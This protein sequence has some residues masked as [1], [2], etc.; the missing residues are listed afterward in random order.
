MLSAP[1]GIR[2]PG[3]LVRRQ[4]HG[5]SSR[6]IYA[7]TSLFYHGPVF[8]CSPVGHPFG[9]PCGCQTGSPDSL[10]VPSQVIGMVRILE[11]PKY[12]VRH[13]LSYQVQVG[14]LGFLVGDL[15]PA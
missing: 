11:T 7:L 2:T 5:I 15:P 14:V 6:S 12:L 9:C 3:P 10:A 4:R 1:G 13:T 8:G